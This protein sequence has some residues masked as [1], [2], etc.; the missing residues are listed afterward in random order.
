MYKKLILLAG[1]AT[2]LLGF[3][4]APAQAQIHAQVQVYPGYVVPPPPR[5]GPPPRPARTWVP[6]HWEYRGP[7]RHWIGGQWVYPRPGHA[8]RPPG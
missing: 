4:T 8:Y 7:H 1:A 5:Y 2:A 6:G 3:A